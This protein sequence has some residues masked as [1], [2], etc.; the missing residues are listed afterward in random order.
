V[1]EGFEGKLSL[2]QEREGEGRKRER[3]RE[4]EDEREGNVQEL[5]DREEFA[6]K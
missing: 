5:P 6:K 2:E 1:L 3:E 4:K